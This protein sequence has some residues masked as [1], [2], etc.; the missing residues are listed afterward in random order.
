MAEERIAKHLDVV[1]IIRNQ[2]INEVTRRLLFTKLERYL[3]RQQ[4]RPFTLSS[5]KVK[6]SDTS[7]FDPLDYVNETTDYQVTL[8]R[9]VHA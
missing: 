4:Q 9:G 6:S 3:M 7:D 5:K 8:L 1:H 2:M